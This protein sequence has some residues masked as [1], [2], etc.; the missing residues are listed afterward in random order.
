MRGKSLQ[1]SMEGE[2]ETADVRGIVSL[3]HLGHL[4]LFMFLALAQ[5]SDQ[6]HVA[7]LTDY[8]SILKEKS[9]SQKP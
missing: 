1:E 9:S 8:F 7:F 4:F 6:S 2:T 5:K 3:R